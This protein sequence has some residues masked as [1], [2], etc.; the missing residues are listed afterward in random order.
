MDNRLDILKNR[1]QGLNSARDFDIPAEMPRPEKAAVRSHRSKLT[2]MYIRLSAVGFISIVLTPIMFA[3]A[4]LP[5]WLSAV[6][7]VYFMLMSVMCQ[8]VLRKLRKLD[9]ANMPTVTLLNRI[10]EIMSMRRL[11]LI[12]GII[13]ASPLVG[14]ML[15]HFRQIDILMF[16]GGLCGLIIGLI[17]GICNDIQ[18]RKHIRAIREELMTAFS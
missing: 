5:S 6:T 9:F 8:C 1:W 18:A 4:G 16:Y 7:I 13:T 10:R 14:F 2:S 11:H 3:K 15:Y 17:I 12:I